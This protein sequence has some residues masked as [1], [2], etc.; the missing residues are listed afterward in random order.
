MW[1]HL[2]APPWAGMEQSSPTLTMEKEM[3]PVLHIHQF[4]AAPSQERLVQTLQSQFADAGV[5][6]LSSYGMARRHRYSQGP[7]ETLS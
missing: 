6:N 4:L 5:K 7:L 1:T 2:R 3:G